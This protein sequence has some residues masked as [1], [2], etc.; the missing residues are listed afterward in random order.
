MSI[1]NMSIPKF[2]AIVALIGLVGFVASAAAHAGPVGDSIFYIAVAC[3]AVATFI[4]LGY[5][6]IEFYREIARAK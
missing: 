2:A 6:V 4:F 3:I 1:P 5:M